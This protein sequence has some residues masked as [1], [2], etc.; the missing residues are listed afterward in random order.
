MRKE[1]RAGHHLNVNSSKSLHP[2]IRGHGSNDY[3]TRLFDC[4]GH[5]HGHWFR[6]P[7]RFTP[8]SAMWM[9]AA[10]LETVINL[11]FNVQTAL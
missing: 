7:G 1:V 3:L 5:Q 10:G 11:C 9:L 6:S 4:A 2:T 8:A